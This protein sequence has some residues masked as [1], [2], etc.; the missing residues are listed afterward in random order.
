MHVTRLDQGL[1]SL[2][3]EGRKMKDPGNE[4][5]QDW[6]TTHTEISLETLWLSGIS[7][8]LRDRNWPTTHNAAFLIRSDSR[9]SC[10]LVLSTMAHFTSN[11]EYRF[12]RK[13]LA[14]DTSHFFERCQRLINIRISSRAGLKHVGLYAHYRQCVSVAS[15]RSISEPGVRK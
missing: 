15:S 4:V 11:A 6:L 13:V 1:S 5:A 12:G 7:T 2:A 14:K 8:T 3:P 10:W 9:L